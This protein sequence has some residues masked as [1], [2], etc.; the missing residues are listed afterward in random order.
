M[1][2]D[3]YENSTAARSVFDQANATLGYPVTRLCFEGP[4]DE[5]QLTIHAQPAIVAVSLAAL[6][7][8]QQ[9]WDGAGYGP[10]PKPAY[11]AGH[12]V[13]ELA[14]MVAAGAM[15]MADGF[16]LVQQRARLMHEAGQATPGGMT[17]VLGLSRETVEALCAEARARLPG[18]YVAVAN[19]NAA[20]QVTVAG[21]AEG[22]ALV[23][24]LAAGR[25]ARRCIPLAVSAAFHSEAMRAA[26]PALAAA[27]R[28]A[29]LRRARVPVV[30]NVT[31]EPES[32][33]AAL[34]A[35]LSEQIYRPVLWAGIMEFM[36][37]S[38]IRRFLE[39]GPGRVL[40]NLAQRLD[41]ALEVREAGDGDGVAAAVAWLRKR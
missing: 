24:R 3:L 22:L 21:D 31:A 15:E 2:R 12:S 26:A 40:S 10:P 33:P 18:S 41:S 23:A 38:G 9:L 30:A 34:A 6:A 16:R 36:V 5:L 1:G 19:H 37:R 8:F 4:A 20:S 39:L 13:G 14:A 28:G 11:A 29:A 32:D 35:E 7:A 27:V 17:A 25:G